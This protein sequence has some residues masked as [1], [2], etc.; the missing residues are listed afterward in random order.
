MRF[1]INKYGKIC[2]FL[3]GVSGYQIDLPVNT[4]IGE[5]H[6]I[7]F[8]ERGRPPKVIII[9][10]LE[11]ERR[12]RELSGKGYEYVNAQRIYV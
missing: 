5:I 9:S 3:S 7:I 6:V 8:K 11:V 12:A 4:G 10:S 2:A 1:I